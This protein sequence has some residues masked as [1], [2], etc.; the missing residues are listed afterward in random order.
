MLGKR[1]TALLLGVGL[2]LAPA[3]ASA[4]GAGDPAPDFTLKDLDDQEYSLSDF[5]GRVVVLKLATTWCPSCKQLS[6]EIEDLG[7]YLKEQNAVFLDVYVQDSPSM[8]RKSLKKRDFVVE[9]HA[10]LDDGQAYTDYNVYVI[11]RLLIIDQQQKVANDTLGQVVS[12]AWI[13]KRVGLLAA[14]ADEA[15]KTE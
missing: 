9:S 13:K 7:P 1:L 8:V 10:L 15:P 11:P 14:A 5:K 12:G 3:L 4:L 2:L 6:D